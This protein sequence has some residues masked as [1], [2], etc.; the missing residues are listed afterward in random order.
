MIFLSI[1]RFSVCLKAI[2]RTTTIST[3]FIWGIVCIQARYVVQ[4]CTVI[5]RRKLNKCEWKRNM[6]LYIIIQASLWS[7]SLQK[8]KIFFFSFTLFDSFLLI[9][10][11]NCRQHPLLLSFSLSQLL[12]ALILL[13]FLFV[14]LFRSVDEWK[15]SH[16]F[17]GYAKNPMNNNGISCERRI[18]NKIRNQCDC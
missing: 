18:T 6:T 16:S 11:I 10:S 14:W 1:E 9:A 15:R 3:I 7:Y 2:E 13:L 4:H 8:N 12:T 17:H 5:L